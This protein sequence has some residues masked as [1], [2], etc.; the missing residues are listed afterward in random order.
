MDKMRCLSKA[1][2]SP[3]KYH[4]AYREN[5]DGNTFDKEVLLFLMGIGNN[6]SRETFQVEPFKKRLP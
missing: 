1:G 4:E 5:V 3:K 2:G 6:V